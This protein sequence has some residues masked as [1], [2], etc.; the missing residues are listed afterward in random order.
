M[1]TVGWLAKDL[2]RVRMFLEEKKAEQE[3]MAAYD[4]IRKECTAMIGEMLTAGG[5][6]TTVEIE[7]DGRSTWWYVCRECHTGI[8]S[9]DH[10]CRNCGRRILWK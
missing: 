10:Y 7:G 9:H 8:D 1:D 3:I 4:E 2:E 6:E 5:M